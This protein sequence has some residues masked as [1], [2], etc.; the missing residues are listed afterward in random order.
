MY[1]FLIQENRLGYLLYNLSGGVQKTTPVICQTKERLFWNLNELIR[2]PDERK[3]P[4]DTP[5]TPQ[6]NQGL[7]SSFYDR[8]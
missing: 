8:G 5:K 4:S 7:G 6:G 3:I 2:E 1:R